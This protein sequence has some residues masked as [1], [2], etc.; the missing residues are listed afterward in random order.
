MPA[1]HWKRRLEIDVAGRHMV[2]DDMQ[3]EFQ[4]RQA[5]NPQPDWAYVRI[6]NLS[7][8]TSHQIFQ[9]GVPVQ[10]NAGYH[11]GPF[12]LIYDGS[13]EQQRIGKLNGTDKYHDILSTS[14]GRAYSYAVVQEPLPAGSTVKDVF[15]RAA[16]AMQKLGVRLGYVGPL[17]DKQFPR[18]RTLNH[19]ARDLLREVAETTDSSWGIFN[20]ELNMVPNKGFLP[21][22]MEIN[23][24]TGMVGFPEQ[25]LTGIVV[26]IFMNATVKINQKVHIDAKAI[27][28][29]LGAGGQQ[30]GA[31]PSEEAG[32][33]AGIAPDGI[34][35]VVRI[36]HDG[37]TK[38]QEW[39]TTLTCVAPG[40]EGP[41]AGAST[42][43]NEI[44]RGVTETEQGQ[45]GG[46]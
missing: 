43:Q 40:K 35:K 10:I 41:G 14:G 1:K 9:K 20:G 19:L 36:D 4:V 17:G 3:V 33:V 24:D 34:Y 16:N 28:K 11:E 5:D 21:G 2:L 22:V 32:T 6:M 29:F 39:Y 46:G 30:P 42:N 13:T 25:Q 7:D 23:G 31:N 45:G 38:G 12:G 26:R 8:Q 37:N 44:G 18:G 15:D 27:Q